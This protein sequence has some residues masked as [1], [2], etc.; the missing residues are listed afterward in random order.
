MESKPL[1][2]EEP[3]SEVSDSHEALVEYDPFSIMGQL[4]RMGTAPEQRNVF[5]DAE[6]RLDRIIEEVD[7]LRRIIRLGKSQ[8]IQSK[9]DDRK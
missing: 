2:K 8:F 4:Q 9:S 1:H 5:D 6:R 3:V 7:E